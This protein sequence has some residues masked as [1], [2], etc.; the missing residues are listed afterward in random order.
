MLSGYLL[1]LLLNTFRLFSGFIAQYFPFVFSV[2]IAPYG[3]RLFG[4]FSAQYF[5][6]I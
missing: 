5:Q 6:V 1:Y 2:H 3:S 4:V